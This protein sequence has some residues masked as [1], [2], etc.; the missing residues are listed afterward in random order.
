[1]NI[2]FITFGSHDH[3]LDA[4]HRL[5]N[6]AKQMNIFNNHLMDAIYCDRNIYGVSKIS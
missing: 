6:Q 3:Y 5:I 4:G 1:M 2:V